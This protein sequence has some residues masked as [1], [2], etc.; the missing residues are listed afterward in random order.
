MPE[1]FENINTYAKTRMSYYNIPF[2]DLA[3]EFITQRQ[4]QKLRKMIYFK[5]DKHPSYNLS[6]RRLKAIEQFIQNRV[7]EL[8]ALENK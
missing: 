4:K 3:R 8:L 2:L 7:H 1:H 6:S 5:F